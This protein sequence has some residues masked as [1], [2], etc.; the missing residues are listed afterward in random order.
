MGACFKSGRVGH[1]KINCTLRT[2]AAAVEGE[3]LNWNVQVRVALGPNPSRS[4][5]RFI[6]FLVIALSIGQ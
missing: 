6:S 2:A 3:E 5:S 4:S 1:M